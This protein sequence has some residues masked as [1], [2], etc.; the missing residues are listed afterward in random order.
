MLSICLAPPKV[1]SKGTLISLRGDGI[2][3]IRPIT[4]PI[5]LAVRLEEDIVSTNIIP[6]YY[7][8]VFK[9]LCTYWYWALRY[10]LASCIT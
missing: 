10:E 5:G 4:L 2:I 8:R 3:G 1:S 9:V 7:I 6:I